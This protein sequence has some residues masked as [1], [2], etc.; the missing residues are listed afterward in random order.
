MEARRFGGK[1]R[2]FRKE[3]A[4]GSTSGNCKEQGEKR[5]RGEATVTF[6]EADHGNKTEE[7]R[8]SGRMTQKGLQKRG[9]ENSGKPKA[10]PDGGK[11]KEQ[12]QK[13]KK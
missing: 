7:E 1:N 4:S 2:V 8:E 10:F 13:K 6:E 3:P 5:I 9:A 12:H 11:P